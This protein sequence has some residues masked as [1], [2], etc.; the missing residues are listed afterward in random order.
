MKPAISAS[1]RNFVKA[2]LAAGI[3]SGTP[4]RAQYA[5]PP[6]TVYKSPSCG[7]CGEWVK[8]LH[9]AGFA[10]K[11]VNIEDL[12]PIKQRYGVPE[13]LGSCHTALVD[14]YVIEGHVPVREIKRLLAERPKAKGLA[15]P[16]MPAGSPGM[17]QGA[18]RDPYD[19]L[20]FNDSGRHSIYSSYRSN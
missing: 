5:L 8:H 11:V 7:C 16:G 17:E 14:G 19:V 4:V 12:T 2:A 9:R 18:R 20:I 6:I 10:T 15:V 1:R 3:L 13:K